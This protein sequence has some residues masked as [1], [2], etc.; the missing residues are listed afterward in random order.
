MKPQLASV[1]ATDPIAADLN[2]LLGKHL[3][4]LVESYTRVPPEQRARTID[5]CG[6]SIE[7]KLVDGLAVVESELARELSANHAALPV[8]GHA[9]DR[10]VAP[11]L[12]LPHRHDVQRLGSGIAAAIRASIAGGGR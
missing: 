3:P 2:R 5:E 11:A 9:T 8:A 12:N 6:T 7:K 1:A 4:D 10:V